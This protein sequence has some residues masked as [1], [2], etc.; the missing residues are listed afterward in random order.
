MALVAIDGAFLRVNNALCELV[1]RH[2]ADLLART[3]QDIT[4]PDDLAADV[5]LLA[6]L[7]IGER[8]DYQIDQRYLRPAGSEAWAQTTVPIVRNQPAHPMHF[9]HQI[10]ALS[11]RPR[12]HTPPTQ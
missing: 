9:V 1:G 2:Q 4:H 3:F 12:L 7:L 6:A 10:Q 5:A 11:E 8:L